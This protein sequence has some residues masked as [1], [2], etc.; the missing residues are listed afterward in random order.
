MSKYSREVAEA[1][2]EA[3]VDRYYETVDSWHFGNPL[4]KAIDASPELKQSL[5]TSVAEGYLERIANQPPDPGAA[6]GYS[7]KD[8]SITLPETL[9]DDRY[10]L[11]FT[12]GHENQHALNSQGH[13]YL[14]QTLFPE[15]ERIRDSGQPPPRDYTQAIADYIDHG[16]EDEARAHIGGFN[17]VASAL[18]AE[19]K[20]ATNTAIA[21][22]LGARADDF[23]VPSGVKG[24]Y[25]TRGLQQNPD[26]SLPFSDQ[27]VTAMKTNYADKF[28]GTFGPNGLMDYRHEYILQGMQAVANVEK[29]GAVERT[30]AFIADHK[31]KNAG[32][33]PPNQ[34][35]VQFLD[36]P[37]KVDFAQIGANP[38]LLR[39]PAD[40]VMTLSN[41]M[42]PPKETTFLGDHPGFVVARPDARQALGLP[43]ETQSKGFFASFFGGSAL[44]EEQGASRSDPATAL[45]RQVADGV[46]ALKDIPGVEGEE[47]R[48]NVAAA[49]SLEAGRQGLASVDHV[50]LNANGDRLIAVQGDPASPEARRADVII[51][52]AR[53]QPFAQSLRSLDDAVH[54]QTQTPDEATRHKSMT[55]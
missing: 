9:L 46:V 10:K 52:D 51:A 38:H 40:G 23:L 44:M 28:P 21:D 7:G 39:T 34:D 5:I 31:Q 11:I 12:L 27:N 19:G 42:Y 30:M 6:A 25:V 43:A 8:K 35:L 13:H 37:V 24:G 53:Q 4:R 2:L 54:A 45:P 49:L 16:R 20:A 26:G 22:R 3:M 33:P 32:Q 47:Q 15:I 17:A 1:R 29:I 55:M 36:V 50:A 48:R 41:P 18:R 14:S